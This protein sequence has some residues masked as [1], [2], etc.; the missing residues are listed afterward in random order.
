MCL[1]DSIMPSNHEFG[2]TQTLLRPEK[3][4][5]DEG[6]YLSGAGALR[7]K[8]LETPGWQGAEVILPN[9]TVGVELDTDS[10][11]ADS[12]AEIS[13][14]VDSIL[15]K[16]SYI[17]EDGYEM[18][19]GEFLSSF[20]ARAKRDFEKTD[21]TKETRPP[22]TLLYD[23]DIRPVEGQI[24]APAAV[25][26]HVP[27]TDEQLHALR[28]K[29]PSEV[30]IIDGATN[31]L[32]DSVGWE[33][34]D[35]AR[36]TKRRASKVGRVAFDSLNFELGDFYDV[37]DRHK[38]TGRSYQQETAEDDVWNMFYGT[39]QNNDQDV[40]DDH[41]STS[42]ARHE[43]TSDQGIPESPEVRAYATVQEATG[44]RAWSSLA[45]DEQRSVRRKLVKEHHPD[46]GGDEEL[47]KALI[48]AMPV[49]PRSGGEQPPEQ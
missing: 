49:E 46:R 31:Q 14:K 15:E 18:L 8:L 26:V 1:Y 6:E 38:Q 41:T 13:E 42:S 32:L 4:K 47:A 19:M 16:G 5:N 39:S 29:L 22:V 9:K 11:D 12:L 36:S 21:A 40:H 27:F 45:G 17:T 30:P 25:I 20:D 37:A 3:I 7:T 28:E 10:F 23:G 48:T 24:A 34:R 44:G 43:I 33:Q 2:Q 35:Q